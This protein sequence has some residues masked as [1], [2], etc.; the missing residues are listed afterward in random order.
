MLCLVSKL[1]AQYRLHAAQT[2]RLKMSL[3]LRPQNS[4]MV[5]FETSRKYNPRLGAVKTYFQAGCLR[6]NKE[7]QMY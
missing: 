6:A 4:T 3:S 1:C 2:R 7:V 5:G